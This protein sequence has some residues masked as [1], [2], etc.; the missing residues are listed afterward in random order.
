MQW[1]GLPSVEGNS[2]A[3]GSFILLRDMG[4][5]KDEHPENRSFR[6]ENRHSGIPSVRESRVD[7]KSPAEQNGGLDFLR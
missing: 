5:R 4:F 1:P 2:T 7:G 3:T 6:G